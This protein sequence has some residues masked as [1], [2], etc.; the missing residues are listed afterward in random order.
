MLVSISYLLSLER[1]YVFFIQAEKYFSLAC[2]KNYTYETSKIFLPYVT[3]LIEI[4][5]SKKIQI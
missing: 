1:T 5:N 4:L 2:I 3:Y